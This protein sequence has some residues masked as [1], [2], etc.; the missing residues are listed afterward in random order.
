M[1]LP[2]HHVARRSCTLLAHGLACFGLVYEETVSKVQY[3]QINPATVVLGVRAR[4]TRVGTRS[5]DGL[6]HS[7]YRSLASLVLDGGLV[8]RW[9]T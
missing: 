4:E 5:S 6:A 2:Q 3:S 8:A 9:R 1:Y 7:H